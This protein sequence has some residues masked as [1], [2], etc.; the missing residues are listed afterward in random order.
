MYNEIKCEVC[1]NWVHFGCIQDVSDLHS[2]QR[3]EKD[4]VCK[5]CKKAIADA[6]SQLTYIKG[7]E[8]KMLNKFYEIL[9]YLTLGF[10]VFMVFYGATMMT[11][12]QQ[13]VLIMTVIMK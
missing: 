10:I 7:L 11:P 6:Q 9:A 8:K 2:M 4:P 12:E 1:G 5:S 13:Q 3:F